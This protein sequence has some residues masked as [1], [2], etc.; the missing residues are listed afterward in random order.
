MQNQTIFKAGNSLALSLPAKLVKKLGLSAGQQ[1]I[2]DYDIPTAQ[3]TA[4]FPDHSQLSLLNSSFEG[5][6]T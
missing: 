3:L 2:I 1:V 5:K 6:N 4:Q